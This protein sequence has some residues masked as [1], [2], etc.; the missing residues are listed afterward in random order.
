MS[1]RILVPTIE[2]VAYMP[3]GSRLNSRT[4]F[5]SER[6]LIDHGGVKWNEL[7]ENQGYR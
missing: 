1:R 7:G 4:A 2:S 6:R 5:E 3:L